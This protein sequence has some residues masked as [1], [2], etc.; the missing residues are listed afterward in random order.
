MWEA[1]ESNR[2]RSQVLIGAIFLINLMLGALCGY[3]WTDDVVGTVLGVFFAILLSAGLLMM[4]LTR[5][6]SIV[7][8]CAGAVELCRDDCPPLVNVV[9]EMT[10]ASGIGRPPKIYL[11]DQESP[12]AFTVGR[13]PES[14]CIVVTSGLIKSMDRDE[15]QGIVAHEIAH[16]A[17]HDARFLTLAS[18]LVGSVVVLSEVLWRSVLLRGG[19]RLSSRAAPQGKA[20]MIVA[21]V[22]AVLAP[23][24]A[25][26]LYAACARRRE[27]LADACAAQFTRY[28][29]GLARALRKIVD[30]GDRSAPVSK[31]FAPFYAVDPL[32]FFS[33]RRSRLKSQP[34]PEERIKILLSIGNSVGLG[35]YEAAYLRV[36]KSRKRLI[37]LRSRSQ[38]SARPVREASPSAS[39]REEAIERARQVMDIV[40]RAAQ[41]VFISCACGLRMKLPPTWTK[42]CVDCP[43]CAQ[44]HAVPCAKA[45]GEEESTREAQTPDEEAA[46]AADVADEPAASEAASESEEA[47]PL[48]FERTGEGWETFRCACGHTVQLSPSYRASK[49][50]C[51]KCRASIEV[52]VAA[53]MAE[54]AVASPSAGSAV[55]PELEEWSSVFS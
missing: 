42:E 33:A 53:A 44:T 29:E 28:P 52:V 4:A 36:T 34:H 16:I 10:I 26:V 38:D 47:A 7:L 20:V 35:E 49:V 43:R 2:R 22:V 30:K 3:I 25:R 1:I 46:V 9:E 5:G 37:G 45:R 39:K 40:D 13:S 48:R 11:L 19:R 14:A 51:R 32:E 17:N 55:E 31:M 23:I 8:A 54:T 27:Y 41:Y 50:S 21:L 24:C 18:V 15:L 12:N 6:E